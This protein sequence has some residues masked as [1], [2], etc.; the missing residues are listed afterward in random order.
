MSHFF[1]TTRFI[2]WGADLIAWNLCMIRL[3]CPQASLREVTC[4]LFHSRLTLSS[5]SFAFLHLNHMNVLESIF[6]AWKTIQIQPEIWVLIC[7]N[8]SGKKTKRKKK[9]R[10]ESTTNTNAIWCQFGWKYLLLKP[11]SETNT[12]SN[13]SS[14]MDRVME[15]LIHFSA[16]WKL[17]VRR[18]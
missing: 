11:L 2:L 12:S 6:N 15:T 10:R 8:H 14:V 18:W 4:T 3:L 5:I 17:V 16:H 7:V 9:K 1:F 13:S